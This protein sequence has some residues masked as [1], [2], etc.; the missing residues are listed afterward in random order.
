EEEK[1]GARSQNGESSFWLLAPGFWL[2]FPPADFSVLL[3]MYVCDASD[4]MR[5]ERVL[6]VDDEKDCRFAL[7][8]ALAAKGFDPDTAENGRTALKQLESRPSIYGLIYT[9]L[10]MPE[11]GGLQLV[12][13][14]ATIDPTIVS[15]MLTGV[16]NTSTTLAVLRAGAYDF[17]AKPYTSA[18]LEFSLA[19]AIERRKLLLK[20]EE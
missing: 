1:P 15:V 6:V 14:V 19:R 8:D 3:L 2:P 16:V 11:V 12:E 20:N 9:D 18:E 7:A 5:M 17:L 13:R 4:K 10:Q